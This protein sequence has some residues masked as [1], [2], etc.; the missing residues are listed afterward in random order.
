MKYLKS[1]IIEELKPEVFKSAADKLSKLGHIKR[2]KEL[3]DWHDKVVERERDLAIK[4]EVKKASELGTYSVRLVVD[5]TICIGDFYIYLYLN[6]EDFHLRYKNWKNFNIDSIYI[7]IEVI[8]YPV[9]DKLYPVHKGGIKNVNFDKISL[10]EIYFNL[11]KFGNNDYGDF[12]CGCFDGEVCDGKYCSAKRSWTL[13]PTGEIMRDNFLFGDRSSAVKFKK[14]ICD[15]FKGNIVV[16]K[17]DDIPGGIKERVLDFLCS[18]MTH[19]LKEFEYFIESLNKIKVN[20][21]YM[22]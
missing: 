2:P 16:D 8:G 1:Y 21:L 17:T 14:L 12:D 7:P 6:E 18:D 22:D 13:Y 10:G 11:T 9:S 15:V 4:N 19:T 3:M 20:S 5:S